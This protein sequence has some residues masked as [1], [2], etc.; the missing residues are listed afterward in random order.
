MKWKK[1]KTSKFY[2]TKIIYYFSYYG[3]SKF[4]TKVE[5]IENNYPNE[6]LTFEIKLSNFK[7]KSLADDKVFKSIIIILKHFLFLYLNKRDFNF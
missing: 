1:K 2:L 3:I 6:L 5:Q 4:G 7:G